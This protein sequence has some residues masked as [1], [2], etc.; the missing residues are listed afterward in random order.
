MQRKMAS[1]Q[2]APWATHSIIVWRAMRA[3]QREN[4]FSWR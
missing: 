4:I 2:K 1:S 3:P